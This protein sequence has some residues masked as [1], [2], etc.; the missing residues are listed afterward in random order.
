[1][2]KQIK[3]KST[4]K[5]VKEPFKAGGVRW[6]AP[7]PPADPEVMVQVVPNQDIKVN[8]VL[9]PAGVACMMDCASAHQFAAVL[10]APSEE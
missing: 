1:M 5:S 7:F 3:T 6:E 4:K 9:R 10:S 2:A 8:G